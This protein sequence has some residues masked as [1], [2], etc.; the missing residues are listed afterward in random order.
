MKRTASSAGRQEDSRRENSTSPD[1]RNCSRSGSPHSVQLPSAGGEMSSDEQEEGTIYGTSGSM[2]ETSHPSDICS[3]SHSLLVTRKSLATSNP[4]ISTGHSSFGS[5]AFSKGIAL[6]ALLTSGTSGVSSFNTANAAAI[7]GTTV[8]TNI[9]GAT[10]RSSIT[11]SSLKPNLAVNTIGGQGS[12]ASTGRKQSISICFICELPILTHQCWST[13]QNE[14]SPGLLTA[15]GAVASA[16]GLVYTN[17][18]Y[19]DDC[20]TCSVCSARLKL[21]G[22]AKR[23]GNSVYCSLHFADVSGLGSGG[24]EFMAKLRD[25]KRQSLGC[26]GEYY[27]DEER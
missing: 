27:Y 1:S 15:S 9:T 22:G 10:H 26:A 21:N 23:H 24:D 19:H 5:P 4:N 8:S 17:V 14:R 11:M 13:W 16:S 7:A 20:L 25:F 3:V 18:I 2:D 6:E 12:V